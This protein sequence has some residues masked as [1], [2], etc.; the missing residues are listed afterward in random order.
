MRD[1]AKMATSNGS[2]HLDP[3]PA[4]QHADRMLREGGPATV[5]LW[6]RTAARLTRLALERAT[7]LYWSRARPEMSA[8]PTTMRILM[9]EVTL[10]RPSARE[11]YLVWSRLSDATHPHPYELAPTV[12]ELRRWHSEVT[13]FVTLLAAATDAVA[14]EHANEHRS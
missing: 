5:G 4:L 6:P 14:F 3:M 9:L 10:G 12:G 1:T 2:R 11:A 8:C 7:D 13:Q